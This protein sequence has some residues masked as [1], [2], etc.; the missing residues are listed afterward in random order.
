MNSTNKMIAGASVAASLFLLSTASAI[1]AGS[2]S[3]KSWDAKE[4]FLIRLR[5][6]D[7][8]P[9]ESSHTTIGG[10]VTVSNQAMPE[11]DF[12]YF[13]SDNIGAE[14]VATAA[15]HDIGAVGTT[16]GNLDLGNVWVLPPTLTLQ[17]HFNPSGTIRPYAG[18]GVSYIH[19]FNVDS[20]SFN[21]IEYKDG[22][23]YALQ[24]GTDIA[25]NEHWAINADIKKV[26]HN[27]HANIN[28]GTVTANVDLDPW[29][30]GVGIAYRF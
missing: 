22:I 14:L 9:D 20:A 16:L 26:Y 4:R 1:A 10:K 30:A 11:V 15:K 28:N 2:V 29:I 18:A 3:G 12:S 24:A 21:S 25:I 6:V 27:T 23:G 7:I 8:I 17:Y 5:A 13:F 19:Y